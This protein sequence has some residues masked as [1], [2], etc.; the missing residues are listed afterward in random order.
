MYRVVQVPEWTFGP[1]QYIEGKRDF[2][3]KPN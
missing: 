3:N 2:R 1:A